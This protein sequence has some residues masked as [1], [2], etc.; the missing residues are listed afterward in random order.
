MTTIEPKKAYEILKEASELCDFTTDFEYVF[1]PKGAFV[2]VTC[3][4]DTEDIEVL[5]KFLELP[6]VS[7]D[8]KPNGPISE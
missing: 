1:T 5:N 4:P 8:D 7:D 2:R 3:I 6:Q